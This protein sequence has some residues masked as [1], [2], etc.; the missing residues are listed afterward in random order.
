MA[1]AAAKSDEKAP[2]VLGKAKGGRPTYSTRVFKK[3]S[4]NG[5]L[6]AYVGRRDFF[7]DGYKVDIVDGVVLV[8]PEYIK[9]SEGRKVYGQLSSCLSFGKGDNVYD[10]NYVASFKKELLNLSVQIYPP[11]NDQ[12]PR[13]KLQERLIRKLGENAYPFQFQIPSRLAASVSLNKT[14]TDDKT[15]PGGVE[16]L[17]QTFAATAPTE[18]IEKRNSVPLAIKKLTALD[19][20]LQKEQP[21]TDTKKSFWGSSYPVNVE[22]RL[23]RFMYYHGDPIV[24]HLNVD[25]RSN[26]TIKSVA[27]SIKQLSEVVVF[28]EKAKCIVTTFTSESG[29]PINPSSHLSQSFSIVPSLQDCSH[30][31]NLAVDGQLKHEDTNLASSTII[32]DNIT[33][34]Q[35]EDL[36][37]VVKY[38]MKVTLHVAFGSDISLKLA[39]GLTHC[40]PSDDVLI[41]RVVHEP[42][43]AAAPAPAPTTEESSADNH[44]TAEPTRGANPAAVAAATATAAPASGGAAAAA[45]N[46]ASAAQRPDPPVGNLISLGDDPSPAPAPQFAST[47][48]FFMPAA[49]GGPAM[50]PAAAGRTAN[51]NEFMDDDIVFE[52]FV[53]LRTAGETDA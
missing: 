12:P 29:F 2:V 14:E 6:T 37:I 47:N 33:D 32:K 13:T 27:I 16:Y 38:M 41:Q 19:A 21:Q 39:F 25:N 7:D 46:T 4:P 23:D 17:L 11:N 26:K 36:G 5:K 1:A 40:R 24:V 42:A 52:E 31:G 53:R 3:S 34:L 18:K 22:A 10:A 43:A 28:K 35:R 48:P 20:S 30:K 50:A 44:Y 8:D 51:V 49:Q 9:K 15:K 45:G